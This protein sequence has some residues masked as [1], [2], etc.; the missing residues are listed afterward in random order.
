MGVT[1]KKKKKKDQTYFKQQGGSP[2]H[3]PGDTR[4]DWVS[5]YAQGVDVLLGE[6]AQSC[7]LPLG[8]GTFKLCV[9][10]TCAAD[11]HIGGGRP[12]QTLWQGLLPQ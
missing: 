5:E 10:N 11:V 4:H 6:Y 7:I 3:A 8:R 9:S 1:K 12:Q 2:L